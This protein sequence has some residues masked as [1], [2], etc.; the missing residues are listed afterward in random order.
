MAVTT[1]TDM[2]V[3]IVT[4]WAEDILASKSTGR[5]DALYQATVA[6]RCPEAVER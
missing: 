1:G 4:V 6:D 2:A 5:T 3:T